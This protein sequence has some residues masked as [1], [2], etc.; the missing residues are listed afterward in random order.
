MEASEEDVR[1]ALEGAL[2][3][4]E[5]SRLGFEERPKPRDPFADDG[6][7]ELITLM[8]VVLWT[9]N[10]VAAGVVGG[11]AWDLTKKAGE[12]LKKRFGDGHVAEAPTG[13]A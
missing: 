4:D 11:A 6:R 5:M 13:K 2:T 9:A 8:T 12:A 1:V 7:G 3:A 10:A